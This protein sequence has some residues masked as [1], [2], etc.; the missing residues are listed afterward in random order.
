MEP[1]SH[2]LEL[3]HKLRADRYKKE[4]EVAERKVSTILAIFSDH[5]SQTFGWT[6]RKP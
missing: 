4:L 6:E 3:T 2:A 1:S 5:S